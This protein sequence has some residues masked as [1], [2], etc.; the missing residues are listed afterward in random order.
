MRGEHGV[1]G[2][3]APVSPRYARQL[4]R[5]GIELAGRGEVRTAAQ[6]H[7]GASSLFPERYM[8]IGS[9]SGSS[10]THCALNAS[11]VR[12]R[13]RRE[14]PRGVHTSRI[15]GSSRCDHPPHLLLD[16][17]QILLGEGPALRGRRKIV[18]ETIVGRRAESDLG[19]W[20]QLLDCLGEDVGVVVTDELERFGF[21]ARRDQR[22]AG[23][24]LRTGA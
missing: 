10:I 7:P 21:V 5:I 14:R 3:A 12:A 18:I 8:V 23:C 6:V 9:P 16:R 2:V 11:P 22:E 17:R 20:E 19:P 4:E 24:R 15:S 13:R 1:L